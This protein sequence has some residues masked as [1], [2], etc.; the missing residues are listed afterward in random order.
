VNYKNKV[1]KIGLFEEYSTMKMIGS[2]LIKSLDWK[3]EQEWRLT[4]FKQ[5]EDFPQK[6][7]VP[8]G[9]AG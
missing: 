1:P 9:F 2:S 3:Y 8:I 6:T 4:I 5:K 7:I